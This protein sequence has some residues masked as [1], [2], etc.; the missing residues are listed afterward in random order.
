M[1]RNTYDLVSIFDEWPYLGK[2]VMVL[3]SRFPKFSVQLAEEVEGTSASPVEVVR[4]LESAGSA[5]VYVDGGKTIQSFL[6]ADL[7]QE[8][9]ITRVP[10]LIGEGIPLFGEL[11]HD[12]RLRHLSTTIFENGLEQSKYRVENAA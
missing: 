9:T 5:H 11:A 2:K 12:I 4:Q 6:Q 3:S 1:G 8:V 10:V 7:I